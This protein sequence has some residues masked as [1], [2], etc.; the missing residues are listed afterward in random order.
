[1]PRASSTTPTMTTAIASG[2]MSLTPGGQGRRRRSPVHLR[3]A[4]TP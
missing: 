3:S 2:R 1:V 4:T